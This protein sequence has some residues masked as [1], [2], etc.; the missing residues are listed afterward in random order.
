M[1]SHG[2]IMAIKEDLNRPTSTWL[3]EEAEERK[4]EEIFSGEPSVEKDNLANL[5]RLNLNRNASMLLVE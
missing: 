5:A 4:T 3:R 2:N 1:H